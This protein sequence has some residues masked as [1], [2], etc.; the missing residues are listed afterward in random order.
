MIP[1]DI[2]VDV[3]E[4]FAG[5]R[6]MKTGSWVNACVEFLQE[7]GFMTRSGKVTEKGREVLRDRR[8]R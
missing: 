6:E 2:E 1:T 5:Y 7:G 8:G 3:L 4:M